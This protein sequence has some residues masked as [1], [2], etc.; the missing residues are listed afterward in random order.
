LLTVFMVNYG[1]RD[2]VEGELELRWW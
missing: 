2:G 1:R